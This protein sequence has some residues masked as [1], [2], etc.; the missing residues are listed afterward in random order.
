MSEEE[1]NRSPKEIQADAQRMLYVAKQAM[2]EMRI[3]LMDAKSSAAMLFPD[4]NYDLN[5]KQDLAEAKAAYQS[6][7]KVHVITD[8]SKPENAELMERM[9]GLYEQVFPLEEEREELQKLLG[10]NKVKTSDAPSLEQWIL[11]ED[12]DGKI[13]AARNV[14]NLSAVKEPRVAADIDGTQSLVYSF[15]DPQVR[16]L[17]LGD[18]T[19]KIAEEEGRRFIASTYGKDKKPETVDMIQVAEQNAP[20][21]MSIE[22]ILVDTAGAKTDQF[23]RRH[24]YESLGFREVGFDYVQLPLVPRDEGGEPCTDL[25]LI[26]R[27][28]PGPES[29]RGLVRQPETLSVEAMRFHLYHFSAYVA[30]GQ[31]DIESDPDW[32]KQS[33]ALDSL[34]EA[35]ERVGVKPKLDFL[36]LK[37]QAWDFMDKAVN[38]KKF[39][40]DA[41]QNTSIG[42]QMGIDTIPSWKPATSPAAVAAPAVRKPG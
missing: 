40:A 34:K 6:T 33:A 27:G 15:V 2:E 17:G 24:Y 28:A 23:W 39:D 5:N 12:Q 21:N 26:V 3:Q 11:L 10:M 32:V 38:S 42:A 37:E 29:N 9:Y 25:N 1:D 14:M 19:L 20:L 31:Y 16:S 4:K 41:F 8:G 22:S 7:L 30:A 36:A 35:G 18:M 13:V